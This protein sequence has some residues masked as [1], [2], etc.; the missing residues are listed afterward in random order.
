MYHSNYG[1]ALANTRQYE[2]ARAQFEAALRLNPNY[3][4]AAASLAKLRQLVAEK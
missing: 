1:T 3:V 4:P 2:A